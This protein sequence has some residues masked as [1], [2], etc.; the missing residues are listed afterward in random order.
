MNHSEALIPP[1]SI[2]LEQAILGA[3]LL[4]SN[5]YDKISTILTADSFYN[6]KHSKLFATICEMKS[7][8]NHID[9]LTITEYATK[10][11][12][13]NDIGGVVYVSGLTMNIASSGHI[14]QHA[15]IIQEK[16]IQREVISKSRELINVAFSDGYDEI[17][18]SYSDLTGQIDNLLA[19]KTMMRHVRDIAND[20]AKNLEER[21]K[22]TKAGGMAGVDTGLTV[23]NNKTK[24]W[25]SGQL[26]ILASRPAMGKTAIA[27]NMFS[28]A[29]AQSGKHVN[30]F[31]LEMEDVSLFDRLALSWGGISKDRFKSGELNPMEYSN[32]TSAYSKLSELNIWIDDNHS[33]S[34]NYIRSVARSKV[35]KHECDLVVIDYL[36]L[37]DTPNSK[38]NRERE[39]ATMS[40]GLKS[41]AK[42]LGI[43][44]ILLCQLNRGVES[45]T[46]FE[47]KRPQ[48]SDLRE[49]G[50]IE[51]DAD[52]VIMPWRPEYYE[53]Y[54]DDAQQDM[55][56][57]VLLEI[58]K[59]RDGDTG[60]VMAKK[61]NEFTQI[62]DVNEDFDNEEIKAADPFDGMPD[63]V[64][65]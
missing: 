6:P 9:M 37:I 19:G 43:P 27:L 65:F 34:L 15:Q 7:K 51:Q 10:K 64:E 60:A 26:I 13:L 21:A 16:Y 62:G 50:A 52:I 20:S 54:Q 40:R 5:A 31:S 36:Q 30:Y 25:Q 24:G 44:V 11:N 39:V 28:K 49:S 23:L 17:M 61:N 4:E 14:K 12:I 57:L 1:Q 58:R 29:A 2:E 18:S 42:E 35:R 45:R 8:G 63:E 22:R 41:M 32:L 55:T 38:M 46:G 3:C 33:T 48:L 53:I 59:H 47:G 56:N